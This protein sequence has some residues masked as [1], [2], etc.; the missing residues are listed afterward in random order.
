M[1]YGVRLLDL[2]AGEQPLTALTHTPQT[3]LHLD[4]ASRKAV[5]WTIRPLRGLAR[6]WP[7][8]WP[9]WDLEFRQDRCQR[10][11]VVVPDPD[12]ARGRLE[13][14]NRFIALWASERA[15]TNY[16]NTVNA[17]LWSSSH[18]PEDE[19][20]DIRRRSRRAAEAAM[21]D[22]TAEFEAIAVDIARGLR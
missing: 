16:K 12:V 1:E 7:R 3:G 14:A 13:L 20:R 10:Y 15:Y 19:R 2:L 18:G 4:T 8:L 22:A 6:R 5:L 17:T 21:E 11:P 9:G